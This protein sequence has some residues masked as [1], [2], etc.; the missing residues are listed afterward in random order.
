MNEAGEKGFY[1]YDMKDDER[2]I[3]RYFEDPAIS[4][5]VTKEV[6][7]ELALHTTRFTMITVSLKILLIVT[8]VSCNHSAGHPSVVVFT[9]GSGKKG[10]SRMNWVTRR[11]VRGQP[12]ETAGKAEEPE[13][14]R[15]QRIIRNM[16]VRMIPG[17]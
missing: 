15:I 3:Q 5:S 7:D 17:L 1:R 9:R 12:A 13:L 10:G 11:T 8:I 4:G 14:W 2:T 6:Y 16:P